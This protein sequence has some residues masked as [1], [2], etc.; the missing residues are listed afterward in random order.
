MVILIWRNAMLWIFWRIRFLHDTWMERRGQ[1][2]ASQASY[3]YDSD[4][5]GNQHDLI[6]QQLDEVEGDLRRSGPPH[7]RLR[8]EEKY[9]T[10]HEGHA[11]DGGLLRDSATGDASTSPASSPRVMLDRGD[12]AD[13]EAR[14]DYHSRSRICYWASNVDLAIR[15]QTV[16]QIASQCDER[17]EK[18]FV[19]PSSPRA[20]LEKSPTWLRHLDWKSYYPRWANDAQTVSTVDFSSNDWCLLKKDTMLWRD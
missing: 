11:S 16:Q 4:I 20:A 5:D 13:P 9:I 2:S 19:F 14:A 6:T 3:I 8:E 1:G 18:D 10:V 15:H 12:H 17:R 7:D